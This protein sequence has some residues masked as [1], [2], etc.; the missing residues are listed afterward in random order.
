MKGPRRSS[1]SMSSSWWKGGTWGLAA[2]L[3]ACG[4]PPERAATA[5]PSTGAPLVLD[6]APTAET[7]EDDAPLARLEMWWSD[8]GTAVARCLHDGEVALTLLTASGEKQPLPIDYP[9]AGW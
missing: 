1:R 7:P 8:A 4:S 3:A 2:I 6:E 9:Q 5:P